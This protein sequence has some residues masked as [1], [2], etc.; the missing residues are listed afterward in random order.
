MSKIWGDIVNIVASRPELL[1]FFRSNAVVSIGDGQ[2]ASFWTDSWSG[3]F[4]LRDEFPRLYSLSNGKDG[5][6]S[7]Y[8]S[9]RDASRNWVF[10]F[11]RPL[12]AWEEG[13][14]RR[15][16]IHLSSFPLLIANVPDCLKWNA[17]PSGVFSVSSA[18]HWFELGFGSSCM[19]SSSLWKNAAPPRVQFF[20]WLAWRGR[21]KTASF[22][23]RIG[24]LNGN[25]DVC[26]IFCKEMEET[27]IHVLLH[28]PF[29]WWIWSYFVNW[30]GLQWVLPGSVQDLL[31]WWAGCRHTKM[32]KKIWSV[33]PLAILWSIWKQRN[34]C[35]FNGVQRSLDALCENIKVIIAVWVKSAFT[36][37]YF[38]YDLIRDLNQVKIMPQF[39][40]DG[41]GEPIGCTLDVIIKTT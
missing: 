22:L 40:Y 5:S 30:W 36:L 34:D 9:N 38:V 8:H 23:R 27:S 29:V 19:V 41:S 31:D 32:V 7:L 24:M 16:S 26:C 20:G 25:V 37:D 39:E 2:I 21:I 10:N 18:Y 4:C 3:G 14:L 35:V 11:R 6:V 17:T 15:L 12:F 1:H 13:E 33:V 28:C